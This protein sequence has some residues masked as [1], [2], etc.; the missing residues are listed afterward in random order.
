[1]RTGLCRSREDLLD[2]LADVIITV[3]VAMSGVTGDVDEASSHLQR[4]LAAVT[5]GSSDLGLCLIGV[6]VDVSGILSAW[7]M[8]TSRARRALWSP[9]LRISR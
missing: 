9:S 4:R 8:G 3:A 7:A 6:N 5:E 2:E 1:M